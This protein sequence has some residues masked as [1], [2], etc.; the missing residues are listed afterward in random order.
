MN[1]TL[2]AMW[3]NNLEQ[4]ARGTLTRIDRKIEQSGGIVNEDQEIMS[5]L[6]MGY[7]YLLHVCEEER[8]L[9]V[10]DPTPIID[11]IDKNKTVH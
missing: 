5:S 11:T 8:L 2:R 3:L 9:D 7:L 6:C 10:E 1:S 4:I